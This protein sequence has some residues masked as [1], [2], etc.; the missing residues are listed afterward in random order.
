L[1][2]FFFPVSSISSSITGENFAG[3]RKEKGGDMKRFFVFGLVLLIF[4]FGLGPFPPK[5]NAVAQPVIAYDFLA[6]ASS[7]SWNKWTSSGASPITF[8]VDD[9][10]FIA[11]DGMAAL[12]SGG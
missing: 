10:S 11:A 1:T 5:N 9:T 12:V 7:A 2:S 8:K 3:P 4:L 6:N